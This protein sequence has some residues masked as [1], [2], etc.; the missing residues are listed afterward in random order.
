MP[1]ALVEIRIVDETGQLVF[2]QVVETNRYTW[3]CWPAEKRASL[4]LEIT[5]EAAATLHSGRAQKIG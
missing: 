1:P 5:A 4:L 2:S 3:E